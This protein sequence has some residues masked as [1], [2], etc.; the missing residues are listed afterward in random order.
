M[1]QRC[2]ETFFGL[3]L[4]SELFGDKVGG[5][6]K[7]S[8]DDSTDVDRDIGSVHLGWLVASGKPYAGMNFFSGRLEVTKPYLM[9]C[10]CTVYTDNWA[11]NSRRLDGFSVVDGQFSFTYCLDVVTIFLAAFGKAIAEVG[12]S[13]FI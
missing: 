11:N 4:E 10:A 6:R 13:F 8:L 7:H 3:S 2:R 5:L 12:S 9:E 1:R